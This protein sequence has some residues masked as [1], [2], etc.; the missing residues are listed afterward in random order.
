MREYAASIHSRKLYAFR[1][2]NSSK[3]RIL[4]IS[5]HE[6][7]SSKE[8]Q[9]YQEEHLE[10]ILK[11]A[12]EKVPYYR[13]YWNEHGL[14]DNK[15]KSLL[16]WPVLTKDTVR[17]NNRLFLSD[18]SNP[19]EMYT[20]FT[21]GT[22]GK[23]LQVWWS[24]ETTLEY[25]AIYERRI[26][27]WHD[28]HLNDAHIL[29]GG[30]MVVPVNRKRPPYWINNK[31]MNQL[32]MSSYHM[33]EES[34]DSYVSVINTFKPKYILGYASSLYTLANLIQ[35]KG[36]KVS[37]IKC[38]ISNAEHLFSYQVQKIME[39]FNCEVVN[40]YGMSELVTGACSDNNW[41]QMYVWPEVGYIETLNTSFVDEND[42]KRI[43]STSLLNTE[44]PLIRYDTGDVG[45]IE[46]AKGRL[47]YKV[48]TSISGRIDDLIVTADGRTIGRLDPIFKEDYKIVE[49]QIIQHSIDQFE[50]VLV[51]DI[52]YNSEL[53]NRIAKNL[54][55]RIGEG[56]IK[57]TLTDKIQR[58]NTGKFNAVISKVTKK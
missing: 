13:N 3:D 22:T 35:K 54:R 41:E 20:E 17:K 40:T 6:S 11:Y 14:I 51:P 18:E 1:Y 44:M 38:A 42:N 36:L 57:I 47:N 9:A 12:I 21:S 5:K 31:F 43:L 55:E 32:Y 27:N 24:K 58:S 34:I 19:S 29:I 26:R 50:I 15:W 37:P 4:E 46:D 28:V 23:P 45:K 2:D 56:D 49:A 33:S 8:W 16:N 25:Y 48:I 10:R 7:Y 52:G 53:G 30:R 39:V